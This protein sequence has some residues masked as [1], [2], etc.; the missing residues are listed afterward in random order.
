[1]RVNQATR[2]EPNERERE[3]M[4][5][6]RQGKPLPPE[7]PKRKRPDRE[8]FA[9][10]A[11]QYTNNEIAEQYGVHASTVTKW[12]QEYQI[13]TKRDPNFG[14][15]RLRA[16]TRGPGKYRQCGACGDWHPESTDYFQKRESRSRRCEM[17]WH[18][19]CR[20][21]EALMRKPLDFPATVDGAPLRYWSQPVSHEGGW[22]V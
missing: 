5:L 9:R 13:K 4:E 15:G 10:L 22:L 19:Y 6:A 11:A 12:S 14:G 2:F 20:A 1:M 3:E 17:L 7:K 16:K 21:C 18:E 8:T